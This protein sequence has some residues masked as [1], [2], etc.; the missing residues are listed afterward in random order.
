M[1]LGSIVS[2]S[3]PHWHPP[4][5]CS[6]PAALLPFEIIIEHLRGEIK[7]AVFEAKPRNAKELWNNRGLEYRVLYILRNSGYIMKY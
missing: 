3:T 4:G 7:N 1:R 5:V 2:T 6:F